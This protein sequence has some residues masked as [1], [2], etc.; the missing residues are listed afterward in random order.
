[1]I[2]EDGP[3]F[4]KVAE[5]KEELAARGASHSGVLKSE[6]RRR[7]VALIITARGA[8]ACGGH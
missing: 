8:A 7:L 3:S 6:L 4:L 5:L 2:H 1:M